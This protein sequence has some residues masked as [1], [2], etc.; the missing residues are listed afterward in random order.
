MYSGS[1]FLNG[2][3]GD[4]YRRKYGGRSKSMGARPDRGSQS[5]A[6]DNGGLEAEVNAP[7]NLEGVTPSAYAELSEEYIAS[8]QG[9]VLTYTL[10]Q[11]RD[12][13]QMLHVLADTTGKYDREEHPPE[14]IVQ[15]FDYSAYEMTVEDSKLKLKESMK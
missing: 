15:G 4:N 14:M 2:T 11:T 5:H 8:M 1:D 13:K 6:D 7:D 3:S 12:G 9:P 10:A